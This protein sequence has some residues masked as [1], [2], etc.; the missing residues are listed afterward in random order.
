MSWWQRWP[1]VALGLFTV[2]FVTV[3]CAHALAKGPSEKS[4]LV[5]LVAA[6]LMA[7]LMSFYLTRELARETLEITAANKDRQKPL[8]WYQQEILSFLHS[9]RYQRLDDL[10][11]EQV[12]SPRGL[13]HMRGNVHL[14]IDAYSITLSGPKGVVRILASLLDLKKN[15]L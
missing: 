6:T 12:Y 13:Q 1:R 5:A 15:F 14:K 7:G 10:E 9:Q 8:S 11:G 4:L 3:A 2:T